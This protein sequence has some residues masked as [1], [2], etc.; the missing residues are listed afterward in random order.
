M[1]FGFALPQ[2]GTVA[3]PDAIT[4]VA[5]RAESVGFDSLWVFDRILSPVDPR[6]PYPALPVKARR[7]G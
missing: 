4:A 3:G 5:Q 7:R 2:C 6:V 1:R